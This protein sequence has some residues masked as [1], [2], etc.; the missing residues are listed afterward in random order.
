VL[1]IGTKNHRPW[2]TLNGQN[3]LVQKKM[4]LLEPTAQI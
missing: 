3:T 2:M 1:S 4:R